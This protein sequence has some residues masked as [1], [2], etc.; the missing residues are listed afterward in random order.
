LSGSSVNRRG[1]PAEV[2]LASVRL[3]VSVPCRAP[4]VF[5]AIKYRAIQTLPPVQAHRPFTQLV[6]VLLG[7]SHDDVLPRFARSKLVWKS[8]GNR[9][10]LT[11]AAV[12]H[13]TPRSGEDCLLRTC[14]FNVAEEVSTGPSAQ[15]REILFVSAALYLVLTLAVWGIGRWRAASRHQVV[16]LERRRDVTGTRRVVVGRRTRHRPR[17]WTAPSPPLNSHDPYR[18]HKIALPGQVVIDELEGPESTDLT[19]VLPWRW[20]DDVNLMLRRV[21]TAPD[22]VTVRW[23]TPGLASA[24]DEPLQVTRRP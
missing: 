9:G 22:A 16:T 18:M 6:R 21:D 15:Q 5:S 8:P 7:G 23:S 1:V 14:G 2:E 3:R 4:D 20:V 10:N 17:R 12:S 19:G 11:S 13:E 24:P